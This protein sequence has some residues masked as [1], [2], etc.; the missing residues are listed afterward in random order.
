LP[1][2]LPATLKPNTK[3]VLNVQVGNAFYNTSDETAPSRSELL[4]GGVLL[5][6]DSDDSPAAGTWDLR[7]LTYNS[8]ENSELLGGMLEIRL[9]AAAPVDGG[10]VDGYKV[11]FNEVVLSIDSGEPEFKRGEANADGTLDVCDYPPA[12]CQ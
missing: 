5:A 3:Y 6:S 8:A 1:Q 12:N 11:D 9:I 7:S 4:A 10:G 2:V